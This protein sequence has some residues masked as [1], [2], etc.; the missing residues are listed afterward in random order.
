MTAPA[1]PISTGTGTIRLNERDKAKALD[2]AQ[3]AAFTRSLMVEPADIAP[4][5]GKQEGKPITQGLQPAKARENYPFKDPAKRGKG[6]PMDSVNRYTGAL[7]EL[8]PSDLADLRIVLAFAS[9]S[10]W[11][12]VA[13]GT[14][15]SGRYALMRIGAAASARARFPGAV[16]DWCRLRYIASL[17]SGELCPWRGTNKF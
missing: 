4:M 14:A 5:P 1:A 3:K 11:C 10:R 7:K 12:W 16:P 9:P 8:R 13:P 6:R 17:K 2:Y 15:A